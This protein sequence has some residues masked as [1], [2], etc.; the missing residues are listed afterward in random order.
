MSK[1]QNEAEVG[2]S[3][4]YKLIAYIAPI[5]IV[6]EGSKVQLDGSQ[7]YIEYNNDNNNNN[8]NNRLSAFSTAT[9]PITGDDRVSFFWEQIDG[10][11][12]TL[13]N[14]N[15]ATPSFT[16]PYV[17]L[18]NSPKKINENLKYQIVI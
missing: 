7:S 5:G 6:A 1:R 16:A 18:S 3:R 15:S 11:L 17:D 12:V 10:P 2:A 9:R 4:K 8:N 13:E 14:S